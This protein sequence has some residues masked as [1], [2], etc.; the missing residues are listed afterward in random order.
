MKKSIS[1][2]ESHRKWK[3]NR[4]DAIKYLQGLSTNPDFPAFLKT[5]IK[6]FMDAHSEGNDDGLNELSDALDVVSKDE[7]TSG[8]EQDISN[9]EPVVNT[10]GNS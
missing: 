7:D 2:E 5:K 6:K 8:A 3:H 9:A 10:S 4:E 1:K